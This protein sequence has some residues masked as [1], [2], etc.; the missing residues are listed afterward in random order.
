MKLDRDAGGAPML[1]LS[2]SFSLTLSFSRTL[3]HTS[4][5]LPLSL[6]FYIS[7]TQTLSLREDNFPFTSDD[8]AI[9]KGAGLYCGPRLRKGEVFAH[10]GSIK[11]LKDLKSHQDRGARPPDHDSSGERPLRVQGHLAHKKAPTPL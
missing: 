8:P 10:V 7:L 5:T 9:R 11:N 3:S 6:S 2:L 1:W 4:H